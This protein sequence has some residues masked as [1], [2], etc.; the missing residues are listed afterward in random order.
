M[1][2]IALIVAIVAFLCALY[3]AFAPNVKKSEPA[4]PIWGG[5]LSLAIA[6][7]IAAFILQL[8]LSLHNI[9]QVH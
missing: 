3:A 8:V 1:N 4:R 7:F 5:W 2:L 6:L 9:V